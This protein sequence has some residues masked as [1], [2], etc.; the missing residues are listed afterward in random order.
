M[1]VL[2]VGSKSIH[3]SSFIE[4]LS[5][6]QSGIFLLSEEECSFKNVQ[7]E[8]RVNFRSLHPI[9]IVKNY[10][11]LKKYLSELK[12]DIIH[13][14]QINRLAYF[15]SRAA[16]KLNI[17]VVS[18]AWGSD[19]LI[20]PNKNKFFKFL[21]KKTIE[22]S[23]VVTADAT[24]MIDG[25][26][27]IVADKNRYELLQYGI[28]L[29]DKSEKSNIVFSNRLHKDLYRIDRI[30]EYFADFLKLN[31]LWKLVIGGTGDKTSEL[32]NLVKKLGIEE[33]VEFVGWLTKE[34]NS[35]WYAKSKIY[36]SIPI[37]DGT[38]VSMLEAISAGCIPV[39]SDIPVSHEWIVDNEN[40]I[41][42]NE[43]ENPLNKA[44][45]LD[46]DNVYTINRK[47]VEKNASRASCTDRFIE[48][49]C[50]AMAK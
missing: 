49:Y 50:K 34:N 7:S 14:H 17:P 30:I 28:D 3:V 38:S 19:V 23:F 29:V 5:K 16:S 37:S 45:F 2:V 26:M 21:T 6:K 9:S 40:G 31:P 20:I 15:A 22:R 27:K 32:E 11:N 44:L 39:L 47:L 1:K 8:H 48:L 33:N 36:I 42:E 43:G 25:M 35:N 46:E 18:T 4:S 41:I 13:I 10:R 24:S 12:P